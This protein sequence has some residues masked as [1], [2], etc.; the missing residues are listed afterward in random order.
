M[1]FNLLDPEVFLD[2]AFRT[3][4]IKQ[5]NGE[6]NKE[7]KRGSLKAFE[8]YKKKQQD[9]IIERLL[10]EFT[11]TSVDDMRKILSINMSRRIINELASVYTHKPERTFATDD[12]SQRELLDTLYEKCDVT[13][14]MKR[15]NRYYKLANQCFMYV[16]PKE[17]KLQTKVYLPHHIDVVPDPRNPEKAIAYVISVMDKFN[18]LNQTDSE[19]YVNRKGGLRQKPQRNKQDEAIGDSEDY[20]SKVGHYIWWTENYHYITDAHGNILDHETMQPREFDPALDSNPITPML[21][22]VDVAETDKD[23]EFFVREG[24]GVTEFAIDMSA[25]ISDLANTSRLQGYAQAVISSEKA[26]KNFITGPNHVLWLKQNPQNP[27]S[28]PTFEFVSPN[29]DLQGSLSIIEFLFEM[30]L[31]QEGLDAKK[32]KG[33]VQFSS[34]VERLL[35]MIDQMQATSADF[36]L[37][38]KVEYHWFELAKAWLDVMAQVSTSDP[39]AL[40]EP[41]RGTIDDNVDLNIKFGKPQ[42]QQSQAEQEDSVIKRLEN[43]LITKVEAIAELRDISIEDAEQI[44]ESMREELR[45]EMSPL[46]PMD[47]ASQEIGQG[48]Q[49][50]SEQQNEDQRDEEG[51]QSDDQS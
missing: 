45:A 30:F 19:D 43:G 17:N 33:N 34:G 41:L 18:F 28:K 42:M 20:E 39:D 10:E 48:L 51:N 13:N 8:I 25:I 23:D 37:F 47:Q 11:Q 31:N 49:Q 46:V 12:D 29:P 40:I 27:E 36:E 14:K 22:F 44:L 2:Q 21:P 50:M 7:R 3:H 16:Y 9:F 26:P 1:Q 38:T 35:A 15:A 4:V 32:I 6:E 24:Y 5:I